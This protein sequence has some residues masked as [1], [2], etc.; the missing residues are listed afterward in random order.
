MVS[1]SS[2]FN[3]LVD[4]EYDTSATEDASEDDTNVLPEPIALLFDSCSINY[5]EVELKETC[6]KSFTDYC[7]ENLQII[8]DHLTSVTLTEARNENCKL[9]RLGR[10][11]ASSFHEACHLKL[12][13]QC[14]SFEEK[15]MRYKNFFSTAATRY[16]TQYESKAREE[17]KME[18]VKYYRNFELQPTGLNV[19]EKFP[20][21]GA[22]PDGLIY[23]NCHGHRILEKKCPHKYKN[24]FE[25]FENN[26]N[27]LL[28][29]NDLIKIN[30]EYNYCQVQ[31]Q[32]PVLD[33][34]NYCDYYIWSKN[35]QKIC[36]V[37]KNDSFCQNM[38]VQLKNVFA[39]KILPEVFRRSMMNYDTQN[40][41]YCACVRPSFEPIITCGSSK[42]Q[43]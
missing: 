32:I 15:I 23:C 10:I 6:S 35:E 25:K 13:S 27:F 4:E 26:K 43:F 19:N 22:S 36:R 5:S 17:Y 38:L 2:I 28:D 20:Q 29:L 8:I 42:C 7:Y 40:R 18:M 34:R 37:E 9:H 16:S 24:D 41:K 21:L 12:D 31:G 14:S 39:L 33:N 1:E 11:T 30:H 3:N